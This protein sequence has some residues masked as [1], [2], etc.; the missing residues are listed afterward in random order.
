MILI[1][2]SVNKFISTL[3]AAIIVCNT[4][5]TLVTTIII[6]ALSWWFILIS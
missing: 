1:F 3:L 6:L 4:L 5:Y 2:G